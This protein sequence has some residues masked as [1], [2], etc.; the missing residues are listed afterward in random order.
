[1]ATTALLSAFSIASY[2]FLNLAAN[3]LNTSTKLAW[4]FPVLRATGGFITA[5]LIQFLIQQ[6]ITTLSDQYLVNRVPLPTPGVDTEAAVQ[7]E[8]G[9]TKKHQL[10]ARTW[11]MLFLLL[12]GLVASVVRYVGCFSIIQ[13]SKSNLGPLGW[14]CLEVGLSVVRLAIWAWNPTGDDAPPLEII[15]KLDE[16]NPFPTCNKD[17]EEIL[18]HKV[19]PL[20]RALDFLKIITSFA[21]L[22][23]P[24]NNPNFS[25]YYTLTRKRPSEESV[26]ANIENDY[27][28]SDNEPEHAEEYKL[29]ESTLY[30]TVFDHKERTTRVYTRDNEIDI[31]YSTKS[32]API[33]DVGHFLL[34]VEIDVKIDP[35]GDPVSSDSNNMDSLRRH[36]QSILEHIHYR[37][38]AGGLCYREQ[39]DNESGGHHQC[40]PE[41]KGG[42]KWKQLE[43]G[44]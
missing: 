30:V 10:D 12:I 33:V 3:N 26:H 34:D 37:L 44:C 1:M 31:F 8:P 11:L 4:V 22:I 39:L 18:R 32:N 20:T 42:R 15:L 43:N 40:A 27:I 36:C 24:F 19:L 38:G 5:T 23:E 17:N 9:D 7:V 2:I 28:D 21:G 14:L 35:E 16:D 6:R 29:G 25:L 13:N 41:V